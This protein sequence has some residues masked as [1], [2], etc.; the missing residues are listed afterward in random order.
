MGIGNNGANHN[1]YGNQRQK[2][3]KGGARRKRAYIFPVHLPVEIIQSEIMPGVLEPLMV[4]VVSDVYEKS[5]GVLSIAAIATLW[6]ASRVR[7][8]C[9]LKSSSIMYSFRITIILRHEDS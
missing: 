8:I 9:L 2:H 3:K 5:A 7:F 6:S 1:Q 4:S